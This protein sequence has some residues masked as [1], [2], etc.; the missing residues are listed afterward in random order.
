[1]NTYTLLATIIAL[2]SQKGGVGKTPTA[3]NLAFALWRRGLKVLLVDI[4]PQGSLTKYFLDNAYKQVDLTIYHALIQNKK[5]ASVPIREGLDL[6]PAINDKQPLTNAEVELP[7]K[8]PFDFQTRLRTIL[9]QY[10]GYNYIIIDTP[11]NVSLFTILALAAAN[12]AVVPVKTEKSAEQAAGETLTLIDQLK[13][14]TGLKLWGILPTLYESRVNHH[15]QVLDLLQQKYKEQ[16][17]PEP[18]KKSNEYNNAH[19]L[20]GDV[21]ELDKSLGEYW[22]RIANSI[23]ETKRG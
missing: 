18:S 10:Q 9:A 2:A 1:M 5:I 14:S 11:G 15:N 4:D 7:Q 12:L 23:I 22:D 13:T 16:V 6:L 20:K 21:S 8:Y 3:I 17:Y 19:A